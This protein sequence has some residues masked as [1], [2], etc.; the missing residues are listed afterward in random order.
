MRR[1]IFWEFARASWQYDIIVA[2]LLVFIFFTPRE[3]F[4]D[5]PRASS[6]VMVP[7]SDG[8]FV[9]YIDPH[10]LGQVSED[11]RRADASRMIEQKYKEK[12]DVVRLETLYDAENEV[13]G[14]LAYAKH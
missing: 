9:F 3:I 4:R 1:W 5:Q 13:K 2:L 8:A 12:W 11:R 10:V 6:V 14:F 7:A